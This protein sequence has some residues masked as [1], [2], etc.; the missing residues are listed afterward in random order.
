MYWI[1]SIIAPLSCKCMTLSDK[2]IT[3]LCYF[4]IMLDVMFI[5]LKLVTA[6]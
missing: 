6:F 1:A 5:K 4:A 2:S 3:T